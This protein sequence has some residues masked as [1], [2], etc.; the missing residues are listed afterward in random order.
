MNVGIPIS[1]EKSPDRVTQPNIFI[2]EATRLLHFTFFSTFYAE[3]VDQSTYGY[4][5][6]SIRFPLRCRNS[7]QKIGTLGLVPS[8]SL[9]S[10][11]FVVDLHSLR[12]SMKIFPSRPLPFT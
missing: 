3:K 10:V 11:E 1:V 12:R 7:E 8:A 2:R 4:D 5:L 6:W 9:A